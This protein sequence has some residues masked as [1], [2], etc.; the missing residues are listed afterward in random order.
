MCGL[1][2]SAW[3]WIPF[4]FWQTPFVLEGEPRVLSELRDQERIL[5]V[6]NHRS[7]SDIFVLCWLARKARKTTS[8]VYLAKRSLLYLPIVGWG[9]YLSGMLMLKR[10]WKSDQSML[11]RAARRFEEHDF[12]YW[13]YL[14]PEGTRY[15]PAVLEASQEF[16]RKKELPVHQHVLQPRQK[17][18]AALV[19]HMPG[20]TG[21]LD[22][23][24][25]YGC[26]SGSFGRF[27]T[28]LCPGVSVQAKFHKMPLLEDTSV[29][30]QNSF[31]EKEGWLKTQRKNT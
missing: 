18:F 25:S 27:L 21:V 9:M 29:F 20:L 23:S 7:W 17:G 30:L 31:A 5:V 24:I 19:E 16:Q 28:G 6:A 2:W 4:G 3:A 10:N 1:V 14:F 26:E 11:R 13:V 15:K 22:V 8:T 12:D